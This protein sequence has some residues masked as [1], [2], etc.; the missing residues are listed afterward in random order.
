MARSDYPNYQINAK[1]N[2]HLKKMNTNMFRFDKFLEPVVV[3]SH[4]RKNYF[5]KALSDLANK[6]NVWVLTFGPLCIKR[7]WKIFAVSLTKISQFWLNF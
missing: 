4:T 3:I 2:L 1:M 5:N 7:F 6:A